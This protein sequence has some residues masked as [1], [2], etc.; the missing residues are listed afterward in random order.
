MKE[1]L[2][3]FV[4]KE[5]RKW[6]I[7]LRRYILQ[8]YGSYM[9]AP[10]FGIDAINFRKWIEIQSKETFSWDNFSS[11]W[12]FDHIIPLSYFDLNDKEDLKLCWNFTNIRIEKGDSSKTKG[13]KV[14]ILTA[15]AYFKDLYK[16]TNY[17]IC[18]KIME[19]ITTLEQSVIENIQPMETFLSQNREYLEGLHDFSEEEYNELNNG[20]SYKDILIEQALFKKFG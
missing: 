8:G 12:Q 20:K 3:S 13:N 15:K 9:Y 4:F 5:K 14:D 19:K 10:Y 11:K 6:Q 7:A 2:D 16:K 18:Y 1:D 17:V